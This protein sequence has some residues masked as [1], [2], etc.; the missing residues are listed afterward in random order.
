VI[1]RRGFLL[2]T[3]AV[4]GAACTQ[5]PPR[6]PA[7]AAARP[8]EFDPWF[9]EAR[10]ILSDSL[11]TLRTFDD[12]QAFRVSTAPG[13][14]MRLDSELAWDPPTSTAWDEATHVTHGLHGRADQLFQAVTTARLDPSLW[15]EQRALGDATHD[16]LDLGETLAAYRDRLDA[17]PPGDA[18]TALGV[19]DRAWKQWDAVG[20]RWGMSR[21]EPLACGT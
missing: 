8:V 12:F 11:Q 4:A 18:S 15:R 20:M 10:G 7:P 5:A 9:Q 19:L 1:G 3:L 14:S 13:S 16:L 6:P 21:G 17:L 2:G